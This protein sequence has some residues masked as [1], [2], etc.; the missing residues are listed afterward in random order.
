[1]VRGGPGD[2]TLSLL[3]H[4]PPTR[5]EFRVAILK[6]GSGNDYLEGGPG[7]DRLLGGVGDDLVRSSDEPSGDDFLS[8]G[9]GD[10]RLAGARGDDVIRGGPGDDVCIPK[11]GN[12]RVYGCERVI[13]D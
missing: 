3:D 7:D 8:G 1:M 9:D 10:D 12:D 13:T 6:G 11:A 4:T 5:M 2:D